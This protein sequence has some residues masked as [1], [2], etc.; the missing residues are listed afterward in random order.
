MV[1]SDSVLH[2][3]AGETTK[4]VPAAKNGVVW[5]EPNWM[6]TVPAPKPTTVPVK[7][8]M[9]SRSPGAVG[10]APEAKMR[11]LS[12][13]GTDREVM[14]DPALIDALVMY[15]LFGLASSLS[16][17][18]SVPKDMHTSTHELVLREYGLAVAD[19]DGILGWTDEPPSEYDADEVVMA[20]DGDG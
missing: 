7:P 5:A 1:L 17:V 9:V 19:A 20:S 16:S 6:S 18:L 8:P 14:V 11:D 10:V 3:W 4:A 13:T 15:E 2:A 12:A